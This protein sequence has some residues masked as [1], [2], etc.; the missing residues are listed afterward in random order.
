M[1]CKLLISVAVLVLPGERLVR[2]IHQ[3]SQDDMA[4][5][6]AGSF[7]GKLICSF[8]AIKIKDSAATLNKTNMW[9]TQSIKK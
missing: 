4:A 6:I 5:S 8:Q 2:L 9:V 1:W 3:D 7:D